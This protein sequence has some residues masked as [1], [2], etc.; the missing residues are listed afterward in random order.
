[1]NQAKPVSMFFSKNSVVGLASAALALLLWTLPNAG[2]AQSTDVLDI[3]GE[4]VSLSDFQHVYGKNN[5]DSVYSVE[6]LDDYMEL[7]INFKLKVREAE[8]MGMDTAE[9]FI[10]ELAGYRS[11][12]ARPYLVD[13]DLLDTMVEE[14]YERKGMEVRA[15][16]ILVNVEDNATPADTLAAWKRI[17]GI[18]A[19]VKSGEDFEAVAR[20]KNGSDDPSAVSNG[21]D[22]GWFTAF[23]MV[24]P[25]ECA[26]F[27]TPEGEVSTV[28]RTRF[29]YHILNV[30]GK[31]KAR[32][33]VQVAH[34]M[35]RMPSDAPQDQVANAEG[36]I[37]EVK[38]LLLSGESFESL[39]LKYSE[40]PSTANK[41]GLLPWFG[42]GKMVE[43]FEDAAFGLEEMGDL[44]GPVRTDYGF[45]LLKLMDKKTLPTFEESRRELSKKV[46][47]DSRAEITKTSFVRAL[48]GEY[49]ASVSNRRREALKAAAT[50]IDS[51]FYPGH[52]LEGVRKSELGRTLFSVA[53]SPRTVEDFLTWANAGKIRNVDRPQAAMVSE[54]I[55]NY[56]AQELL[57]YEDTQLEAKHNDF[58]LLMEEYHDGI[59]LF[60]L[61]D[62][63]V[64]SRA[65]KDTTGLMEFH[66]QNRNEFMWEERL[67]AGIHTCE[68]A[69]I[70]KKVR[71]ELR[72]NSDIEGLRRELI[73]ERPLA[74]R[75][76]FGKFV[77][78]ENGWADRAF[79][80]LRDGSLAPDK[81]G[82][83]IL[84]T[85]EGGDQIILVH[86]KEH[87]MPMP[88]ALDECRGQAIAAYQDH[89]EK[90]W[91]MELRRKYP[92]DINR[93]AFY[94]LVRK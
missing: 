20:S 4:R 44:A 72:K 7:F 31:R 80:A 15:S 79:E 66:G 82:L 34:I 83:T 35:V 3:A 68:D 24:Y 56:V 57:A 9:A 22:L 10:T 54:E 77:E 70:A 43:S 11:Q 32:G 74:L 17:Q 62:Q 90:E 36:R 38:R 51:L 47:R 29:G 30:V 75:N 67:D 64:W 26:A 88:K 19:R 94:S 89:L 21:G 50:K 25:F 1:M 27:N 87:M 85:T 65:V 52:P 55:D 78:G 61:T 39:A 8:A 63:K 76:E 48:K 49:G 86:V 53:G 16:H 6:A 18:R 45:H 41:G 60:E 81:H 59:L 91:I 58:R 28:V 23:Q 37:Q 40:D 84:E 71:K 42:T 92:H 2:M 33:E 93:E 69:K 14:A 5:R 46:R 73:A 12:L 13:G